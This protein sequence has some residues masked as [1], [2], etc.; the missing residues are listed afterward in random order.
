MKAWSGFERSAA[1]FNAQT[2]K[3]V[4]AGEATWSG[5]E[6]SCVE[7]PDDGISVAGVIGKMN[8]EDIFWPS[9]LDT[10]AQ[11]ATGD[12]V[13]EHF[14]VASGGATRTSPEVEAHYIRQQALAWER[15]A[16]LARH[17]EMRRAHK[18]AVRQHT[19]DT[20]ANPMAAALTAAGL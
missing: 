16:E 19:A 8:G 17:A 15:E 3:F 5:D 18:R 14:G 13:A 10:V 12:K 6:A 1:G 11:V 7:V 20:W 4:F 2:G 9:R